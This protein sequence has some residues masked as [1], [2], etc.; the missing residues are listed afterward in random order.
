[1]H[2]IAAVQTDVGNVK[3]VNQDSLTVKIADTALGE[4]AMAVICDGMGGLEQ[5]EVASASVVLAF[6]DWFHNQLPYALFSKEQ[7]FSQEDYIRTSWEK[8]LMEQNRKI[9]D[10]GKAH[11][12]NLGTT[13]TA[14]LWIQDQYYVAHIGDCRLYEITD[15]LVQMTDDQTFV[16]REVALGH[17]TK[18]EA[19]TDSRCNVLL[20]CIGVNAVINPTFLCMPTKK[21]AAYLLC[22]DGFRHEITNQE[23]LRCCGIEHNQN[24][25]NMQQNLAYLLQLNKQRREKDNISAILIRSQE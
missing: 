17:M 2:Y 21:N 25:A 10:Y 8:I 7:Q 24:E 18:E 1:M 14:V 23:I 9:I 12:F 6:E 22:S 5:G 15:T 19:A 16:A 4:V 13:V 11:Q 20:Q 3:K